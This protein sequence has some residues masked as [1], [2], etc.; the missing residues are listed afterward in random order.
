MKY[1]KTKIFRTQIFA[2]LRFMDFIICSIYNFK[3]GSLERFL[4]LYKVEKKHFF[5]FIYIHFTSKYR[6]QMAV[7]ESADR[8][9]SLELLVCIKILVYLFSTHYCTY[10][11]MIL[12]LNNSNNN[13]TENTIS[14]M[15]SI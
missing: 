15:Y 1:L 8:S 6:K 14:A 9:E 12:Q 11:T 3:I 13:Q 2:E 7:I 10:C 4:F 5:M